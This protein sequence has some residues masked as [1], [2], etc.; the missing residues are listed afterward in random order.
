M[1]ELI[2]LNKFILNTKSISNVSGG[3]VLI[4]EAKAGVSSV[5]LSMQISNS[6]DPAQAGSD[7]NNITVDAYI[8]R[9][10]DSIDENPPK[11]YLI[12]QFIIPQTD[13]VNP[14]S[15]KLVLEEGDQIHVNTNGKTDV[16][17]S[18]LENANE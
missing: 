16:V 6:R 14:L 12:K 10:A 17:L 9:A 3:D 18:I 13:A 15:G 8:I 4:Y 2:P 11:F 1:A 5:V 7:P